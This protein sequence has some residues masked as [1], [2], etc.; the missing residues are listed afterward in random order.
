MKIPKVVV[1]YCK[2]CKKH[3]E[4][5]VSIVKPVKR[6]NPLAQSSRRHERKI[7]GYTGFPKPKLEHQKRGKNKIVKKVSLK[8]TCKECKKSEIRSIGRI[9]KTEIK[10]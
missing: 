3:T 1:T 10:R 7:A 9:K 6:R 8:L 5:K 4:H 2:Y